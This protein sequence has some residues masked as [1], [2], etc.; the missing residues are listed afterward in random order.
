MAELVKEKKADICGGH[1]TA[2]VNLDNPYG[3]FWFYTQHL[4]AMM[5]TVFGFGVK[6]V[7]AIKSEK[8]VHAIYDYGDFEV[9]AYFGAGYSVT[10]YTGGFSAESE[11]FALESDF[12]VPEVDTFYE[13][14]KS[15]KPDK[16]KKE[17]VA[18]VYILEATVK[19]FETNETVAI[20]IP[21]F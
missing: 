15:G 17:Y 4:V 3:G 13:V 9:S 12:Y 1:V 2:P 8:G 20:E 21:E 16:S 14:I 6:S 11:S 18:P 10:V 7:K 5:T 19:A